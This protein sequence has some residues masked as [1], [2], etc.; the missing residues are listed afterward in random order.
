V[1]DCIFTEDLRMIP[2]QSTF[3]CTVHWHGNNSDYDNFLRVHRIAFPL[4]QEI[5][6]GGAHHVQNPEQTNP[7][8]L[9]AA[10]VASCMMMTI[11]AVFSR[12]KIVIKTYRDDPVALLELVERRY[13]VTKVTL[14]PKIVVEG[15]VDQ[16]KFANLIQKS[17]ANCFIT[18]SVN[19]EVVVEPEFI[20]E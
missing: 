13:K 3:T 9:F 6:G 14:K 19:S 1:S 18:L 20:S 16:E 15:P 2:E 8:E 4:G 7:E 5:T 11:L 17:H 12:S 10:S